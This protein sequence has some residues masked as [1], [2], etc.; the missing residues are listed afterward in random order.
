MDP[1]IA[2]KPT[3]WRLS[4]PQDDGRGHTSPTQVWLLNDEHPD[5]INDGWEITNVTDA[6]NWTDLPASY[7]NN[8][9]GFNFCDGHSEIKKWQEASTH[10]KV[11]YAQYNGF[12]APKSRDIAWMIEHSSAKR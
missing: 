1:G 8:A 6:N 11:K 7:H 5:S 10:V 9:C 3:Q 12:P 4:Q 2:N